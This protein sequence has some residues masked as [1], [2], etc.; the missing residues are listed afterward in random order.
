M[1]NLLNILICVLFI[2]TTQT[3]LI[4]LQIRKM[5]MIDKFSQD[6]WK[7]YSIKQYNREI[8]FVGINIKK[9]FLKV[10]FRLAI[11]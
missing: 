2:C 9:Y 5:L 8:S 11:Q 10:Q 7:K 6:I 3:I 1:V 4:L